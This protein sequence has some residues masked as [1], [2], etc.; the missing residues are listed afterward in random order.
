MNIEKL[1]ELIELSKLLEWWEVEEKNTIIGKEFIGKYVLV[2]W[3]DA[4]V[5]AW[6]LQESTLGNIILTEARMLWRWWAKEWIGL[7]WIATHWLA[8]KDTNKILQEQKKICIT[9]MRVSTLLEC[10]AEA[11][12]SIREYEVAKQS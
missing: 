5:W 8:I 12:K 3:Y 9:D 7:S 2:K 4:W 1:K 10:S 11:E 6:V